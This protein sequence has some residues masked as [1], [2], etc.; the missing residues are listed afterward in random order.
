MIFGK[1]KVLAHC[2]KGN[3]VK[4]LVAR[5]KDGKVSCY[6]IEDVKGNGASARY[7]TYKEAIAVWNRYKANGWKQF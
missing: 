5:K 1:G 4:R 6:A 3:S 7:D 2:I